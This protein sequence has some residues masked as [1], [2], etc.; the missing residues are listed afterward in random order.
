MDACQN[1]QYSGIVKTNNEFGVTMK[2]QHLWTPPVC[3]V[4]SSQ[5]LTFV[6]TGSCISSAKNCFSLIISVALLIR[7]CCNIAWYVK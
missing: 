4:G 6:V 5:H 7:N 1:S 3:K 2:T